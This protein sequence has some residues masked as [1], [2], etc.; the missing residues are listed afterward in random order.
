M[1]SSVMMKRT[2]P[3]A[4]RADLNWGRL[5]ASLNWSAITEAIVHPG[6]KRCEVIRGAP[7]IR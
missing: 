1:I 7:P 4:M 3:S 6:W 5:A 2:T